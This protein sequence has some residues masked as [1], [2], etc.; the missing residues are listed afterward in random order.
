[1]FSLSISISA[2]K[3][4]TFVSKFP[5][6]IFSEAVIKNV[7]DGDIIW[8]HDYQLLL[9]PKMIRDVN[10]NVTIGFFLHIPFPSFEIFRIFP[11]R[12]ELLQGILGADQIGF[13]TYDYER[14]FLS[15][16]KRILKNDVDF[17]RIGLGSRKVVVDTFNTFKDNNFSVCSFFRT[18]IHYHNN[19]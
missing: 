9:C 6:P 13:H 15:S 17:N 1:M 18:F 5:F 11:W 7:E 10:P 12:E 14:H 19:V 16:V 4:G 2:F 3:S 8:V